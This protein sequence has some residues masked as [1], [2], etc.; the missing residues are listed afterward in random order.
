MFS[1]Y[2]SRKIKQSLMFYLGIELLFILLIGAANLFFSK[3]KEISKASGISSQNLISLIN[4]ERTKNGISP[5]QSNPQLNQAAISKVQEMES[6]NYFSHF[7]PSGKRGVSFIDDQGFVYEKA[8]ENLAVY[9]DSDEEIVAAWMNSAGHRQNILDPDFSETGIAAIVGKYNNFETTYVVQFFAKPLVQKV[10]QTKSEPIQTPVQKV[11]PS[12]PVQ[13]PV[14]TKNTT[15]TEP[16]NPKVAETKK[17]EPKP[18]PIPTKIQT[19]E[20][21]D[22]F[23]KTPTLFNP[24]FLSLENFIKDLK[25]F[26]L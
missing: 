22:L 15:Q 10:S 19:P 1:R 8:A 17:P 14:D 6:Q 23:L 26:N 18:I 25:M 9:Y 7:S 13:T 20:K 4:S 2:F 16:E 12:E 3:P 21:S 11:E 5:L 24:I